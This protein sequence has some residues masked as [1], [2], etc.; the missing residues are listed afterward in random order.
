[1]K[2]I[3]VLAISLIFMFSFT[4]CKE[5]DDLNTEP[6]DTSSSLTDSN[7]E[8]ISDTS[9]SIEMG[10]TVANN[11]DDNILVCSSPSEFYYEDF[12]DG[13]IINLFPNYNQIEYDKI[14]IPSEIDGKKVVGIGSVEQ[15]Y[16]VFGAIYGDCEV[17]IPDTVRYIGDYAF[18]F[19]YGLVRVSGGEN[20]ETIGSSAFMGCENLKEVTFIDNVVNVA[21]DAF[22]GCTSYNQ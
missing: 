9:G 8:D 20:C 13:V 14:I 18:R 10:S 12:E 17:V 1:M 22:I 4:A 2:K 3:L 6:T 15:K 5:N 7:N 19:S 11:E 21:E 16:N